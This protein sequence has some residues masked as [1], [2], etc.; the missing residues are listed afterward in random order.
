MYNFFVVV[1]FIKRSNGLSFRFMY[2]F[3]VLNL[4]NPNI[5]C[6]LKMFFRFLYQE[7]VQILWKRECFLLQ[8]TCLLMVQHLMTASAAENVLSH[9]KEYVYSNHLIGNEVTHTV[10][11]NDITV[12][13]RFCC[14]TRRVKINR[15]LVNGCIN[16]CTGTARNTLHT[17]KRSSSFSSHLQILLIFTHLL[18][19]H[20]RD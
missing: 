20:S 10:T 4:K 13:H 3:L 17:E 18:V 12:T 15:S 2:K 14:L 19:I 11:H 6:S 8:A 9:P 16:D 7:H 5:R 1:S